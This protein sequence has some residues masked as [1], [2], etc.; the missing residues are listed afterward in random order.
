MCSVCDGHSLDALRLCSD[1]ERRCEPCYCLWAQ[2]RI[3]EL[4][5][6]LTLTEA[7]LASAEEA[8]RGPLVAK[9]VSETE[10]DWPCGTLSI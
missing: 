9:T 4:E 3:E 6:L 2:G 1:G 5:T 8:L 7:A 10:E